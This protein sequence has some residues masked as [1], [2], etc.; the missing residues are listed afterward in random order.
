MRVTYADGLSRPQ[1]EVTKPSVVS[2]FPSS[3]PRQQLV[4]TKMMSRVPGTMYMGDFPTEDAQSHKY[5]TLHENFHTVC[6]YILTQQTT[7]TH[8]CDLWNC[9]QQPALNRVPNSHRAS[10]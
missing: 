4:R 9:D 2:V 8:N 7:Q 5:I 3:G 10:A 6:P 1:G